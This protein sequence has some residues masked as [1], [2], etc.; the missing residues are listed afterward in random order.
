M[1]IDAQ[2]H[3]NDK[4]KSILTE[5]TI[6]IEIELQSRSISIDRLNVHGL[7]QVSH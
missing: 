7:L 3:S 1:E 2:I 6:K 4:P 5:I